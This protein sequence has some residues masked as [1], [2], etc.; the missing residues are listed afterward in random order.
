[1]S[2]VHRAGEKLFVDYA[3][4]SIGYGR[5]GYRAQICV[6]TLGASYVRLM[7]MHGSMAGLD[8]RFAFCGFSQGYHRSSCRA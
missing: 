8:R 7:I 3:D 5:E 1:M 6:A 2:Q 4:Q